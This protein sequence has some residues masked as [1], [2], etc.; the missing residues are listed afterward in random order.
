M[1]GKGMTYDTGFVRNGRVSREE[2]DPEVV[3]REL[4][5]IRNDLHC[6][7]VQ[8]VGGDP[9]RLELAARCAAEVGLEVWFSPYPLDLTPDEIATLFVDCAERAERIRRTGAEVVFV[10][11]VELSIMNHGFIPGES[12]SERLDLLLGDP[13]ARPA[14]FAEVS[15]RLN[16]FFGEVLPRVRA[17]FEGKVTYACIQFEQ[18]DWTPFDYLSMEL[19][20]SA[21][22]A[23]RFR[24]GVRTLVAQGKP[25][26]VTGFG[27][28]TWS[29]SGDVAPRSMEIAEH[30]AYGD[31]IRLN[32]HYTRDEAGQ[33]AYL[34][35]LLEIFD[36]EG[37]DSTFVFL[38]ALYNYPHRPNGDPRDDLDLAGLGIVKVLE[39]RRG[40]TY[41]DMAWE[42]KMA[43]TAV[44]EHYRK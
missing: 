15:T 9:G 21:E 22:V 39:D 38:F 23:D 14:R 40:H 8:I 34:R 5:I 10:A 25:V 27:T 29:G 16:D 20:R 43:F 19:I 42:P 1:R 13:D 26:A 7:A 3:G 2:F 6:T 30:D 33:A 37:V 36:S 35:E 12:T 28:A 4:S 18:I 31:P 32:G 24:E 41:P 11:G 44:A 17:R